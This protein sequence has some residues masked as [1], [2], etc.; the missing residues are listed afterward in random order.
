LCRAHQ[1]G[2]GRECQVPPS[3]QKTNYKG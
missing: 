1:T 2:W 3:G